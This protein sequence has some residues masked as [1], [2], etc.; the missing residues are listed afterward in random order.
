MYTK[1]EQSEIE[2]LLKAKTLLSGYIADQTDAEQHEYDL[3]DEL[4]KIIS[5][6]ENPVFFGGDFQ[7]ED[8]IMRAQDR[9]IT[10]TEEQ[11]RSIAQDIE[12]NHDCEYGLCWDT[13]DIY[14][15]T[16]VET[17]SNSQG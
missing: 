13:I 15:D 5:K 7:I 17:A 11:A 8:I 10:L 12:H 16:A 9:E 2:T 1:F 6:I 4:E 14:T 3:L